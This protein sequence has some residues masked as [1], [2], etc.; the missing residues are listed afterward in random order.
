[1]TAATPGAVRP[2]RAVATR[3]AVA[4]AMPV[5]V[6][7]GGSGDGDGDAE[8]EYGWD[9]PFGDVTVSNNN[10]VLYRIID[11][12]ACDRAQTYLDEQWRTLLTPRAALLYQAASDLCRGDVE[13]ARHSFER[14]GSD[15]GWAGVLRPYLDCNVYQ[16]AQSVFE[17]QPP[18]AFVCEDG[19]A[20]AWPTGVPEADRVD[21]RV[22]L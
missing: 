7:G 16:A 19:L 13:S 18:S 10:D 9:L 20:P 5:A 8:D 1:M 4:A 17:Q 21:P 3:A 6:P 22:S 12:G 11:S 2:H 14:A 15:Y